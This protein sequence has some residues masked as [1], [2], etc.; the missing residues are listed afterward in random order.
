MFISQDGEVLHFELASINV[1]CFLTV[2]FK[3][4]L[5]NRLTMWCHCFE[6][7]KRDLENMR[8]GGEIQRFGI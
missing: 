6:N 4:Q 8:G 5:G 1:I 2:K 3:K 7:K